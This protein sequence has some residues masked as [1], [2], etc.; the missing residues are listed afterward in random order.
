MMSCQVWDGWTDGVPGGR[1]SRMWNSQ[2][3]CWLECLPLFPFLC[4][5]VSVC[6]VLC[7]CVC[8]SKPSTELRSQ[9]LTDRR[10]LR[11]STRIRKFNTHQHMLK[12][13]IH[14]T[15]H[16]HT[17]AG[18][19]CKNYVPS[20]LLYIFKFKVEM[21]VLCVFIQFYKFLFLFL[22]LLARPHEQQLLLQSVNPG[23][24]STLPHR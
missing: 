1:V 13:T 4:V 17:C 9:Q 20:I 6:G 16:T 10:R 22:D 24:L 5:C 14:T 7:V 3:P 21:T 2:Y 11:E 12:K 18:V 19:H 15:T 8:S 23:W